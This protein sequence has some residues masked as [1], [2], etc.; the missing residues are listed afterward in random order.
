MHR[1]GRSNRG[2]ADVLAVSPHTVEVY[3]ARVFANLDSSTAP[4]DTR[5]VLAGHGWFNQ[6]SAD[7]PTNPAG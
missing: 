1:R 6:V 5:R 2:I 4:A 7:H 3:V